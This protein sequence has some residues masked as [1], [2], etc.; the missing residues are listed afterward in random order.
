[1]LSVSHK[2]EQ[3]V[4]ED[5]WTL[6]LL[7]QTNKMKWFETEEHIEDAFDFPL[8]VVAWPS[9]KRKHHSLDISRDLKFKRES[10]YSYSNPEVE[11]MIHHGH[12]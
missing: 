7:L 2:K 4:C 11:S 3:H 12:T 10:T 5:A 8:I 1:M 9:E 6:G